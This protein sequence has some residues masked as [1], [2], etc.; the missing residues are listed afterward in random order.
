MNNVLVCLPFN[1]ST[2]PWTVRQLVSQCWPASLSVTAWVYVRCKTVNTSA[3][4]HS[5][6]S[7]SIVLGG[8]IVFLC[9]ILN[10]ITGDRFK[11]NMGQS[12]SVH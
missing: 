8:I 2:G 9:F 11:L 6:V 5:F 12:L 4:C 3:L 10:D 1:L 7:S